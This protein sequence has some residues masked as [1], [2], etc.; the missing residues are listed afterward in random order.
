VEQSSY[1]TSALSLPVFKN[2]LKTHLFR[3]YCDVPSSVLIALVVFLL[4]RGQTNVHKVTYA[5]DHPT[6]GVDNLACLENLAEV[7]RCFFSLFFI[8]F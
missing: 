5:T 3:R 6:A 8:I 7:C 2:R 1:V 4:E